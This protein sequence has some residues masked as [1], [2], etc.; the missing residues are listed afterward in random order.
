MAGLLSLVGSWVGGQKSGFMQDSP[1]NVFL[2]PCDPEGNVDKDQTRAFQF[3]PPEISD[4]Y[5]PNWSNKTIPGGSVP[6]YQFIA[7]GEHTIS[8][9]ATFARDLAGEFGP[10]PGQLTE[11]KHDVDIEAAIAYLRSLSTP[12]YDTKKQFVLPPPLIYLVIPKNAISPSASRTSVPDQMLCIMA[13]CDVT[14]KRWFPDGTT[15]LAEVS[16]QFN[17][18]VQKPKSIKWSGRSAWQTVAKN[19]RWR[20]NNTGY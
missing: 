9:T 10:A 5:S 20:G 8:F 19:Y 12:T 14:R 2:I 15:R 1:S 17:E 13:Q 7:M 18:T 4:N 3:W 11:S 16:L 6:L